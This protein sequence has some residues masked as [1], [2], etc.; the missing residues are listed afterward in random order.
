[1]SRLQSSLASM[2]HSDEALHRW[3][4]DMVKRRAPKRASFTPA[5]NPRSALLGDL[6]LP[7]AGQGRHM[8]FQIVLDTSNASMVWSSNIWAEAVERDAYVGN[9]EAHGE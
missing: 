4:F 7:F 6:R 3:R 5:L 9:R 8:E 1:M 2:R